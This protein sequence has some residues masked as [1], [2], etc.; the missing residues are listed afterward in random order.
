VT[1]FVIAQLKFKDLAAYGR[2]Q[3]AFGEVFRQFSG[4]LL[5]A[6]AA[7]RVV[8]GSW[9]ADKLVLI[10]FP[11]ELSYQAWA[12]SPHYQRIS[13]DRQAGADGVVLLVQGV[14][15]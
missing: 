4:T 11:D 8:E 1:V 15:A 2:Y 6:D 7:P 14:R 5:A 9:P 12:N 10:S 13:V 3:A